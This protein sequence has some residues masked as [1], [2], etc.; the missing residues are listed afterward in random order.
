MLTNEINK[1]VVVSTIVVSTLIRN[2]IMAKQNT[3]DCVEFG[4]TC[5][6]YNMR[7]TSRAITQLYEEFLKPSGL[8]PTQFTLLAAIKVMGPVQMSKIADELILDR[9]TLTRNIRLLEKEGY[10]SIISIKEDQRIREINITS[11]GLKKL[12]QATPYWQKAQDLIKDMLSNSRV[13]RMLDD[14]R[15]TV[16]VTS[17][18]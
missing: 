11:V 4:Q 16:N 15:T 8:L 6:V 17:K 12:K 18:F 9:S 7:R 5:V 13:D 14:L 2:K 3:K 10:L 1:N